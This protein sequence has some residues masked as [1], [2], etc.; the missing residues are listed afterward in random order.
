MPNKMRAAQISKPNGAF[1]LVERDIP[2][3]GPG[4]VRIKIAAC[5]VCHSDMIVKGGQW[6][7]LVLPR[8]PGHEVAGKIDMIGAGVTK[9]KVGDAVGVGWHG[10]YCGVCEQCRR[11]NFISCETN[12]VTGISFDGGYAEY[13]VAPGSAVAKMPDD[14]VP[15]EAAP[16]MCAGITTFNALRNSPAVPPDLVAVLGLGGLGHLAVQYSVKMGFNTVAIARGQDKAALVKQLG[17]RIY[18]DSTSQDPAKELL[19]LGGAKVILSTVTAA[20]AMEAAAG[21]LGANGTFMVIGATGPMKVDALNLLLGRRSVKGWA[22]G[23]SID[24]QDTLAFSALT[25][26]KSMNEIYPFDQV[27]EAFERMESGKARFRVV[28]KM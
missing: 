24:T 19:K 21:G 17:A 23:T 27:N 10:G 1:E 3:P 12:Q 6:P 28:L 13:M 14:L 15:I 26:V 22:S 11:G 2:T 16:L 18:I 9:W 20:D 25:G 7:G 8:V 4:E 5:G